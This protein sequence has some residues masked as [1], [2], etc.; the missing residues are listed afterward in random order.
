[1]RARIRTA[2]PGRLLLA[3]ALALL[4]ACSA[5]P[6]LPPLPPDAR[7]LAF[8]D[9][10]THGTGAGDGESYP[11]VLAR[12]TGRE[13]IEAGVPGEVSA[14]GLARL[15]GLLD[16]H[17]PA[18]L[19]LCQGGNDMLRKLDLA[20]TAANLRAMVRM[21]KERG[22]AVVL[23][24]V[25]R[26]GIFLSTADFYREVAAAE[27][28]PFDGEALPDILGDAALKADAVHPN[29]AGYR[30]LAERVH[31]LLVEAGALQEGR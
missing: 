13:V 28:V 12:L 21:A 17:R 26:P 22:I 27:Q 4:A 18:L 15:P 2:L 30:R 8:G 20:R 23:L 31:A 3:A 14:D 25:P 1:M 7:I 16:K 19:V 9:S 24:G 11:E 29:A 10:L 5:G 6:S